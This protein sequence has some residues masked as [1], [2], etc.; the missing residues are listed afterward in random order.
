[1]QTND[2]FSK[3]FMRIL[4]CLV[5]FRTVLATTSNPELLDS[6]QREI[7]AFIGL[8]A[9]IQTKIKS[10]STIFK[11]IYLYAM[12]EFINI[13]LK[14]A[15]V[16]GFQEETNL[17]LLE[18][19]L[20]TILFQT[21][22]FEHSYA[23]SVIIIKHLLLWYI[24]GD[25]SGEIKLLEPVAV[26]I[27]IKIFSLWALFESN[28][29]VYLK[30]N[31]DVKEALRKKNIQ[32]TELLRSFS[33]GLLIVDKQ[34]NI[35]YRNEMISTILKNDT[36]NYYSELKEIKTQ[37]TDVCIADQIIQ[38]RWDNLR[39]PV[40]LGITNSNEI[41]YEWTVKLIDWEDELSY[42]ITV[43]DVT[44]SLVFERIT[45]ENRT[46]TQLMRSISH[47]LQT[48]I[49]AILLILEDI[50]TDIPEV[51]KEKLSMMSTCTELL[52][53]QIGDILDFSD[54]MSGTLILNSAEC[55]LK[56][57][58]ISCASLIKAQA[59]HKGLEMILKIDPSI[60]DVCY[61]DG[62]RIQK[63]VMN[64][65]SNA[66]K[67]TYQGAIELCATNIGSTIEIK[68]IDSGIG[69]QKERLDQ[70]F[71]MFNYDHD[72]SAMSGLGLHISNN[73]LKLAGINMKVQST[74]GEGSVFS[75]A[76]DAFIDSPGFELSGEIEIPIETWKRTLIPRTI[77]REF[78]QSSPKILIVDDNDFNRMILGSILRQESIQYIEAANGEIAVQ[79]ILRLDTCRNHINCVIMD[80][81]MPVMDGWE[82]TRSIHSKYRL[83]LLKHLPAIIGHTAYSSRDDIHKCYK[84]G[85]ISHFLKPTTK[86]HF[87]SIVNKYI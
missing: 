59:E 40:S 44:K 43:K 68:V 8:L 39:I 50:K 26:G 41:L 13:I 23:Y 21:K 36:E 66:I 7:I 18:S 5:I 47:E 86:E 16:H 67:Y 32:M 3:I 58:L 29:R 27:C 35:K 48:P 38:I 19:T 80:C 87:L 62:F 71:Q 42:M 83:G 70:I 20:L 45:A 51:L 34:F 73:I 57:Y 53:Y 76:I 37:N 1:M 56:T 14:L 69:I 2:M 74:V 75:F 6:P 33:E 81:N 72:S 64:L 17:L 22:V 4:L 77:A 52:N 54:Y 63:V 12:I 60:P 85:M 30:E 28:K 49:N 25:F 24:C 78:Q 84:S 11:Q 10:Y 65:L 46:K 55:N 31:F 15:S 82:A 61:I 9:W 79:T